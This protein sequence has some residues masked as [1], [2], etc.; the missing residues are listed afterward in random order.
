MTTQALETAVK[1]MQEGAL[2]DVTIVC[3]TDDHQAGKDEVGVLLNAW[4]DAIIEC[5]KTYMLGV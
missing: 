5:L 2:Y 4:L 1:A 3:T